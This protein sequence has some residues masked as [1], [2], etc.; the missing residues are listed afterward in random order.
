MD[1]EPLAKVEPN[2]R[3]SYDILAR[4]NERG[5]FKIVES[6]LDKTQAELFARQLCADDH[7][8]HT[9]FREIKGWDFV[10]NAP[11]I[12]RVRQPREPKQPEPDFSFLD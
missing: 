4:Y 7:F 12:P 3:G 1:N 5:K 10:E 2:K 8:R 11:V 9:V 6:L